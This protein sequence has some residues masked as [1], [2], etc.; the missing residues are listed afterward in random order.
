MMLENCCYGE[1]E[2]FA[3]KLAHDGLLGTLTHAEGG[4]IHNLVNRQLENHFRNRGLMEPGKIIHRY[5]NTYP[6]HPLGP[7]CM[8]MDMNR[9]DRMERVVSMSSLS[10][11]HTEY[12][13]VK[14][15]ADEWQ[16][17]IDWRTGDVNTSIIRTARGRTIMLQVDM[18][19]PRPYSRINLIEGTKGCFCDYP[20]RLLVSDV[21]GQVSEEIGGH[22]YWMNDEEFAK[23]K[24][25]HSHPLWKRIGEMAKKNGIEN[26]AKLYSHFASKI[27]DIC[28]EVGRKPIV[29][30]GFPKEGNDVISKDATVVSW[31]NTYQPAADL[32]EGGFNIINAAWKPLYIVARRPWSLIEEDFNVYR[33]DSF[34]PHS[35]AYNGIQFEP[36]DRII[37]AMLCQWECSYEEE[38]DRIRIDLPVLGD[39]TWNESDY[40]TKDE[41]MSLYPRIKEMEEKLY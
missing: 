33:W 8:Y 14:F 30:E 29:W 17:K 39:R 41:F 18:S 31:E 36:T 16:N 6:T 34:M 38:C 13:K 26:T 7:I 35:A 37:G 40:Y 22:G 28:K 1:T 24:E 10:A 11:A 2:M 3:W 9:G 12:A 21:P 15:G 32:L 5:G 4:Y 19:T 25:E 23:F 27:V 20:P